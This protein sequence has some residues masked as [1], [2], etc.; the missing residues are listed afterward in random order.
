M[1][2]FD[3]LVP[4]AGASFVSIEDTVSPVGK[5]LKSVFKRGIMKIHYPELGVCG[6]SCRLCPAYHAGP[7]RWCDGCKRKKRIAVGC[8]FLTCSL[9]KKGVEFCWDCADSAEC[10]RWRKHRVYGMKAD[11]FKCYQMLEHDIAFVRRKGIFEFVRDQERR[12]RLLK[13]MLHEFNEGRSKS[14]YCIAATVFPPEELKGAVKKAQKESRG[15]DI[16][17]RSKVLHSIL[18]EIAMKNNYTLKLRK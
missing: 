18:D 9:K 10:E 8:P 12:E 17:A 4:I 14:Y 11:S 3:G 15:L 1:K 7:T 13:E 16:K 6:L 2:D 5:S